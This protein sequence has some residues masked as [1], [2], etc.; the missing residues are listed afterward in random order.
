[1]AA[2]VGWLLAGACSRSAKGTVRLASVLGPQPL[3]LCVRPLHLQAVAARP[4]FERAARQASTGLVWPTARRLGLLGLGLRLGPGIGLFPSLLR[5][6][7][8]NPPQRMPTAKHPAKALLLDGTVE[9]EEEP[10]P[11]V[12]TAFPWR[13]FLRLLVPDIGWL[14]LAVATAF[15]TALMNIKIP[16]AL[17]RLVNLIND[18]AKA[19]SFDRQLLHSAGMGLLGLY[20]IHGAL[21]AVYIALLAYVGES[22]AERMRKMLYEAIVTQDI[23]FFDVHHSGELVGRLTNDVQEFKSAFKSTISNGL[24]STTQF[25]GSVTALFLISPQLTMLTVVIVPAMVGAGSL[26]GHFLRKLSRAAQTQVGVATAVAEESIGNMRTVRAFAMEDH[27]IATYT[28]EVNK[29]ASINT[30]LGIGI[31]LFQGASSLAINSMTL[32]VLYY[33][34]LLIHEGS[35]TGGDLM[36]FLVSTQM[37]QRAMGNLSMLFGALIRGT[38]AGARVFEYMLLQP[39]IPV[40]GGHIPDTV[41]GEIEFR[42]VD[43]FYPS[44]P[45]KPVLTSFRLTAVAGSVLALCGPS[46]SGKSTIGSLIERFYDPVRGQVLLDGVDI[47]SIDPMWLRGKLIGYIGQEPTLFAASVMENIRYGRMDATDEEVYEA[48]RQANAHTFITEF[49]K[50]YNTVVGERGVTLSGGQR[51]RIAIARALLKNPHILILDEAT[52]AL[53]AESERLVQEALDRV[54]AGRTVIV[55]AHRLST[56]RNA[57]CIAVMKRGRILEMG[58]HEQLMSLRGLYADLVNRQI[59]PDDLQQDD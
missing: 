28:E 26:F 39:S 24:R 58:T 15:G 38:A 35:L 3:R 29:A 42:D 59:S 27:E 37:V 14:L 22:L 13:A 16:A 5:C 4:L 20:G 11:P 36:S 52:S 33:G 45:G 53:D 6:E 17:G 40:K 57:D 9:E 55:I 44:R 12:H 18:M 1:M 32:A 50:G 21:T 56:I 7:A 48:A 47:R 54:L 43:F 19:G 46:G 34:G 25:V 8:A 23:A 51:Q 2:R 10:A 41:R 49:P 30:W 31:G